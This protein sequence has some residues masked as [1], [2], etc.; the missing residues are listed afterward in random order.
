MEQAAYRGSMVHQRCA[1]FDRG[2]IDED[3]ELE[4]E[5]ALFLQAW[6]NF[7][8][9]YSPEWEYIELPMAATD[10]A[11][12]VDRIGIIDRYRTVV[13]IKTL[14]NM[15]RA[16][17]VAV[18]AQIY[19]YQYLALCNGI[20]PIRANEGLA[21]QLKKDG[22]YSVYKVK[23]LEAKYAFNAAEL[24]QSLKNIQRIAKGGKIIE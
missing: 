21:V 4:T 5:S 15:D 8:H 17:K 6:V 7:C 1:D 16:A 24:W 9:D 20:Q 2:L 13:E 23:D 12:T 18:C 14:Q 3:Y 11:G 19:G 10:C 22:T